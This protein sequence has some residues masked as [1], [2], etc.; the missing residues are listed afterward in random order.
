MFSPPLPGFRICIEKLANPSNAYYE[1]TIQHVEPESFEI[2]YNSK[3]FD[4]SENESEFL[5]GKKNQWKT[6][7]SPEVTERA[8]NL[9]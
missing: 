8:S 1:M 7:I 3:K 9:T 5:I 4:T 6:Y 2:F